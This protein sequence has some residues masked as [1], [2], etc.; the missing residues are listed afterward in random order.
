MKI[1]NRASL[2]VRAESNNSKGFGKNPHSLRPIVFPP[3]ELKESDLE[4]SGNI[5]ISSATLVSP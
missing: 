5:K 2:P 4:L 1:E 3:S